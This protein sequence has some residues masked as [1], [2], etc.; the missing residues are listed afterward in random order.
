MGKELGINP[1]FFRSA[2]MKKL[3]ALLC[4]VAVLAVSVGCTAKK[5]NTPPKSAPPVD[6]GAAPA[7]KPADK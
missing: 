6:G 2:S 5:E 1:L 7:D 4:A 3:F